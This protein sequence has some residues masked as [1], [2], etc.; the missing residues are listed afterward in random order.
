MIRFV[1][2]HEVAAVVLQHAV[3]RALEETLG[4]TSRQSGCRIQKRALAEAGTRELVTESRDVEAADGIVE[5]ELVDAA[6]ARHLAEAQAAL[7]VER[8]RQDAI[9][10]RDHDRLPARLDPERVECPRDD[11]S[12]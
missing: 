12:L 5:L 3:D 10:P 6:F 9:E 1:V 7:G 8:R 2:E 11:G 4:G